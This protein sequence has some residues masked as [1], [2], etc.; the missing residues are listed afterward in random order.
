MFSKQAPDLLRILHMGGACCHGADPMC[1]GCITSQLVSGPQAQMYPSHAV[2]TWLD[3]IIKVDLF[4]IIEPLLEHIV[5]TCPQCFLRNKA[6]NGICAYLGASLH[7]CKQVVKK[8]G[9]KNKTGK[10][11]LKN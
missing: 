8:K 10:C 4:L 3:L 11:L 2:Q 9:R 5:C 7:T 1:P 6:Q